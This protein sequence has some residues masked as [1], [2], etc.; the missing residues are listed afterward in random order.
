MGPPGEEWRKRGGG[1]PAEKRERR[2]K[3]EAG[4]E[5]ES[6]EAVGAVVH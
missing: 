4:R 6:D 1:Q 2:F 3:L 5:S